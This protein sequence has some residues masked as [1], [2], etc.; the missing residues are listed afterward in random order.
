MGRL[1]QRG[2]EDMRR[3]A[4]AVFAREL[5]G[6]PESLRRDLFDELTMVSDWNNWRYLREACGRTPEEARVVLRNAVR[7]I[8][9]A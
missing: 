5:R 9:A 1:V 7:R 8:L 6:L 3:A 2:R 4:A